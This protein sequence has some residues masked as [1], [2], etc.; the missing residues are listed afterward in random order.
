MAMQVW[1]A[2]KGTGS[3]FHEMVAKNQLLWMADNRIVFPWEK[4]GWLHL[5]SLAPGREGSRSC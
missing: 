1:A 3:L 5:Y 2:D 4:T